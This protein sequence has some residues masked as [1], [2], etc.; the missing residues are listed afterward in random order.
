MALDESSN[1]KISKSEASK[2]PKFEQKIK[3]NQPFL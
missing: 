2:M 3:I 1:Y